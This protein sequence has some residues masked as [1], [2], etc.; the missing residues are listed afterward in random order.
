M[1]KSVYLAKAKTNW[2]ISSHLES[3][4]RDDPVGTPNVFCLKPHL[5]SATLAQCMSIP[6]PFF[7]IPFAG[8]DRSGVVSLSVATLRPNHCVQNIEEKNAKQK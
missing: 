7:C 5:H 8:V 4:S 2:L 6:L 3:G 1:R